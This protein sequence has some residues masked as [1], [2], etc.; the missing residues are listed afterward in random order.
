LAQELE[1]LQGSA[2]SYPW[3]IFERNLAKRVLE[4]HRLSQSLEPYLKEDTNNPVHDLVEDLLGI[5]PPTW[6]LVQQTNHTI[7]RLAMIGNAIL[8]GRGGHL[9]TANLDHVFHVRL[10]APLN[11]RVRH[12]ADARQVSQRQAASLIEAE[13]AAKARYIRRNFK[14]RLQDPLQFHL[15]INT[16]RVDF[17]VAARL[18]ADIVWNRS[19]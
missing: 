5:H 13:D 15:T 8:I 3:A 19:S 4:D 16:G 2:V 6:R 10:V 7:L 14:I 1:A 9:V 12:V 18:I 11:A 17:A